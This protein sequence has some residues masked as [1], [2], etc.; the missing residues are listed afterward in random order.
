[1]QIQYVFEIFQILDTQEP[2]YFKKIKKIAGE[3]L[4]SVSF[5][6]NLVAKYYTEGRWCGAV[7]HTALLVRWK[8]LIFC[9]LI[10]PD[11]DPTSSGG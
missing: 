8:V 2:I 9:S 7:Q 10:I 6:N 4:R 5:H 11:P 3:K 1:M